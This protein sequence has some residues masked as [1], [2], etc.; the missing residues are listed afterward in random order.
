MSQGKVKYEKLFFNNTRSIV[1]K[2]AIYVEDSHILPD[3]PAK[4][5]QT[6]QEILYRFIYEKLDP[7]RFIFKKPDPIKDDKM[8]LVDDTDTLLRGLPKIY[9]RPTVLICVSNIVDSLIELF[10]DGNAITDYSY[11][12]LSAIIEKGIRKAN[13]ATERKSNF[14]DPDFDENIEDYKN[15]PKKPYWYLQGSIMPK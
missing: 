11:M 2:R 14:R 1:V 8:A 7:V 12:L 4:D 13:G 6:H 10:T 9:L 5:K 3:T 15:L